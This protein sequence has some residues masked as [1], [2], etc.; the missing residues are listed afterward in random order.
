MTS[1]ATERLTRQNG[2]KEDV[3]TEG[4][5]TST[6]QLVEDGILVQCEGKLLCLVLRHE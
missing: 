1:E 2:E 6:A 4:D 5:Q 3:V